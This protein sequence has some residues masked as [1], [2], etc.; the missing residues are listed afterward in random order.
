[1]WAILRE[2]G[3][4]GVAAR[5]RC[6][7]GFARYLAERTRNHPELELLCEPGFSIVCYRYAPSPRPSRE[8][9]N[10]I[11]AQIAEEL[12]HTTTTVPTTTVVNGCFALRACFINPRTTR[13]DI[14]AL[15]DAT[16]TMGRAL[17]STDQ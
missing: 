17:V 6:D 9:L 10:R 8:Q 1:M 16:V 14:D 2:I 7:V 3:C 11:N 4:D 13:H 12:R 5:V 15:I